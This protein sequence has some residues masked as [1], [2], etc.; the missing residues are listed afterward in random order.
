MDGWMDG[1]SISV[2][3]CL[4]HAVSRSLASNRAVPDNSY[5]SNCK[6]SAVAFWQ[7]R[8]VVKFLL[9]SGRYAVIMRILLAVLELPRTDGH[10]EGKLGASQVFDLGGCWPRAGPTDQHYRVG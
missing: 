5:S 10:R 2:Y 7:T 4:L 6:V 1:R 3:W 8:N 9:N